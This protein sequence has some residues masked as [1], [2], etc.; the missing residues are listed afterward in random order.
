[1]PS[2]PLGNAGADFG[3]RLGKIA[4][5]VDRGRRDTLTSAALAAKAEQERM[6]RRDSGGDMRLS[7]VGRRGAKV[8]ARYDVRGN[9]VEVK[10]IGPLHFVAHDTKAHRMPRVRG[11]R[12][13]RRYVVIPG[14]GVRAYAMHP[15]TRGKDTW[16]RG[17]EAAA[18]KVTKIMRSE[19]ANVVKRGF[20]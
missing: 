9:R 19:L 11:R 8:G 1:M 20:G 5:A 16:N 17:R 10:A 18:P 7:G 2:K 12:A 4:M 13:R 3:R 14:V 6:I 15:G